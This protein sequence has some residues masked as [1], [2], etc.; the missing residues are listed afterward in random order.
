[1]QKTLTTLALGL[2]VIGMAFAVGWTVPRS[3]AVPA[4]LS[5]GVPSGTAFTYQGLLRDSSGPLDVNC[6]FVFKLY[7]EAVDGTRIGPIVDRGAVN[8]DDGLFTTLLDFGGSTFDGSERYMDI[9]VRCPTAEQG[10][11]STLSPRQLITP[12][13]QAMFSS[14]A[15]S[16]PWSGLTG[17]PSDLA[18]G[19]D[20]T[21]FDGADFAISDQDCSGGVVTGVDASGVVV[22]ATDADTHLS[23]A[24][25][26]GFV[27]NGALDLATG[28]TLGGGSVSTGP[29]TSNLDWNQITDRPTAIGELSCSSAQTARWSGSQWVCADS[30]PRFTRVGTD[31]LDVS[32]LSVAIGSDGL[33]LIAF[34][35]TAPGVQDLKIAHCDNT[36]CSSST[37]ATIDASGTVGL[38]ASLTIGVD[39]FG[40]ISYFEGVGSDGNLKVAHCDNAACTAATITTL[41]NGVGFDG[42]SVTLGGEVTSI[43]V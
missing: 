13:P 18:D 29:H 22:C 21:T 31:S 41:A 8:L 36:V 3:P 2:L 6:D 35:D 27:T 9:A 30:A 32:D 28:T 14:V 5:V 15:G 33:A 23:E 25:V 39:G 42:S 40:L 38:S 1:M 11:F 10:P 17:V 4:P 7:D 34:R 37:I 12:A 24:Q 43:G 20:D 16:S 26:E 19:D